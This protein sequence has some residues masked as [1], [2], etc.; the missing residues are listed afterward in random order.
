MPLYDILNEFQK[1]HSHI[2]VVYRDSKET[3]P[4]TKEGINIYNLCN[5]AKQFLY[6]SFMQKFNL[7]SDFALLFIEKAYQ[8][9]SYSFLSSS[10]LTNKV[11]GLI[12]F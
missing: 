4:K 9:P 6:I 3:L 8:L 1:G 10:I 5:D 2:A 7:K 12:C 11:H